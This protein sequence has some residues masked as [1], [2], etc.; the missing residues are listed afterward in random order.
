LALGLATLLA[1]T[2]AG[3]QTVVRGQVLDAA[4]TTGVAGASVAVRQGSGALAVGST[5]ADG[6]FVLAFEMGASRD[7]R[8]VTLLVEHPGYVSGSRTLT[9]T[10]GAPDSPFYRIDL[11]P[12]AIASCRLERP[13]LVVVGHFRSPATTQ[14]V[15]DLSLRIADALTYSL[16]TR[17]QQVHVPSDFQ[18]I[19]LACDEV[20]LR[21]V[22]LA[23]SYARALQAHVFVSGDVQP[24]DDHFRVSTYV[25]DRYDLFT[26]PLRTVNRGVDLDDPGAAEV[27]AVTHAA[28]LLAVAVGYQQAGKPAPC[29]DVTLAA[30]DVLGEINPGLLTAV[31]ERRRQ[32]QEQLPHRGLLVGGGS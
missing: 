28:I 23:G 32:C 19:F 30:E 5:E 24:D 17:L 26:P 29:V 9:I 18:P 12:S 21:T 25:G 4:T 16:L 11:L 22:S 14:P 1:T 15:S 10:G 27:D 13:H 2:V 7:A 31:R 8:P 3:A 6:G 20:Q